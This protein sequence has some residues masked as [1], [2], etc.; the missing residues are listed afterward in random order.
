MV[1]AP[2]IL[3]INVRLKKWAA[4]N[5]IQ[6]DMFGPDNVSKV[7]EMGEEEPTTWDKKYDIIT[8]K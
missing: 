8:R 3:N 4:A 7:N 6:T 1:C 2:I 5:A